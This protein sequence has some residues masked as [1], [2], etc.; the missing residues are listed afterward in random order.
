ML[1]SSKFL[2]PLSPSRQPGTQSGTMCSCTGYDPQSYLPQKQPPTHFLPLQSNEA[3]FSLML[4]LPA[5]WFQSRGCHMR[6]P[7]QSNGTCGQRSSCSSAAATQVLKSPPRPGPELQS[8]LTG[9][10]RTRTVQ[11][12]SGWSTRQKHEVPASW[13]RA[14]DSFPNAHSPP[15]PLIPPQ[16]HGGS[17]LLKK[18][19]KVLSPDEIVLLI[20]H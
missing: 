9:T 17:T 5:V 14:N 2:A 16:C 6:Q 1:T 7:P 11:S 4:P 3:L 10:E 18:L 20:I 8:Q 15:L 19:N 13:L 12:E